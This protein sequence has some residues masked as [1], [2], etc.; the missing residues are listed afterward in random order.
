MSLPENL[1]GGA[2]QATNW[3]GDLKGWFTQLVRYINAGLRKQHFTLTAST[4]GTS[5]DFSGI[6]PYAKRITVGFVGVSQ[7]SAA[8]TIIIQV[9]NETPQTT[10]YLGAASGLAGGASTEVNPTNGFAVTNGI[11]ATAVLHGSITLTLMDAETNTWT[12]SG[13][14]GLSNTGA[15]TIAGSSVSISGGPLTMVRLTTVAGT[16]TFDAGNV[17][18]FVE[19]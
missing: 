4:S 3:A 18:I 15:A 14:L 6:L 10:G 7:N 1:S 13:V 17:N 16:A 5:I 9:G 11:A 2:P 12:C 8:T 19:Y